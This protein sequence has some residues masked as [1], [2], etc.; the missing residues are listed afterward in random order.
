MFKEMLVLWKCSKKNYIKPLQYKNPQW[1]Q[2]NIIAFNGT[3]AIH[4]APS[5]KRCIYT[6]AITFR[7]EFKLQKL[8][9]LQS[10]SQSNHLD[11]DGPVKKKLR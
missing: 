5:A 4:F 10:K 3:S 2:N 8:R 6:T 11:L 9:E 1:Q 7:E